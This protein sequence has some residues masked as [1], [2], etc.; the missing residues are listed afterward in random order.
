MEMLGRAKFP[1][2]IVDAFAKDT[3][4]VVGVLQEMFGPERAYELAL[5]MAE[6]TE[7]T[8]SRFRMRCENTMK[9][10]F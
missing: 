7:K 1:E 10:C 8:I 4:E 2:K 3:E 5:S 6:P 9:R